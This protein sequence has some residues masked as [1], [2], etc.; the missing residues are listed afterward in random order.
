MII[1]TAALVIITALVITG[2]DIAASWGRILQPVREYINKNFA[3]R[4]ANPTI[5][6]LYCMSSLW[7]V[8][9]YVVLTV[10]GIINIDPL[11]LIVVIPA[12]AA[13]VKIIDVFIYKD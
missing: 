8:Y 7:S 12:V 2:I 13:V 10:T 4:I 9:T 6:C 3:E 5:G 11:I 1:E